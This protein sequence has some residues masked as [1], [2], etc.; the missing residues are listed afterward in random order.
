MVGTR[1][2]GGKKS[3]YGARKM[4]KA[5][6][7]M[8]YNL[9]NKIFDIADININRDNFAYF[10]FALK[11]QF[12]KNGIDLST[13]DINEPL[14]SDIVLYMGLNQ[15]I[16]N[17]KSYTNFYL[18]TLESPHVDSAIYT[19]N[20]HKFFK[21]I[22]TWNDDMVDNKKY[23]KVNYAYDIPKTIPK[24]FDGKKL[25]C[26]IAGNKSANHPDE[27]YTKRVEFIRWFEKYHLDE[28]DLYGTHWDEYRFG[29]S[30]FGRALNKLKF[31]RK[32]SFPSYKGKVESKFET[33]KDYK[34]S[35]C[36]ENIKDQNGYI[37]EKI[38]DSFF[39][40]CVPIYWGAKNVTTHIPK[41]CFIDKRDFNSFEE[42]YEYIKNMNEATY[43]RYLEA[44]EEFL[45]SSKAD[46][47]RAEIFA[48]TIVG[49]IVKDL[50]DNN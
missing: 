28:F 37:T 20:K 16:I 12:K 38:F 17:T 24:K 48:D 32:S 18:L 35:I 11:E 31:L 2:G 9:G 29:R 8:N 33:M 47:F 26:T 41:E 13:K 42:I 50:N 30:L 43:M 14:S 4:L 23:F 25:C 5:S 49:E 19:L 44:I 36:Y 34:F 45:N 1:L 27:L 21:K 40:G 15:E 3:N 7:V 46:Q 22:F 10:Y 6:L 39:A